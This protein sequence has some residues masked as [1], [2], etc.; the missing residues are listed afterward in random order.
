MNYLGIFSLAEGL[1]PFNSSNLLIASLNSFDN[2]TAR[3]LSEASGSLK[4]GS[5]PGVS[6]FVCFEPKDKMRSNIRKKAL[7]SA[8]TA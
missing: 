1:I 4:N 3:L 6:F 5:Y 8:T 7:N 2:S